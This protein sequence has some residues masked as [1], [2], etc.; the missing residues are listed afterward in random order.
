M[1]KSLKSRS[2]KG[3]V[4][5]LG[6]TILQQGTTFIVTIFLARLLS[7]A[8][9]GLVGMAMVFITI[10]QVFID[11]GFASALI[12]RQDNTNLTYSS[13]FYLNLFFGVILSSTLYFCAP[14]IGA[15][16]KN[17][18]I[19]NLVRWLSLIFVFSSLDIVQITILK[20][21][22]NFK[23][24]TI[25]MFVASIIGGVCAIIAAFL[26]LGVYSLVIQNLVTAALGTIMLW[27][28]TEWRPNL[29]FSFGEIKKLTGFSSY[30]FSDRILS[31]IVSKMDVMTIAKLFSPQVLGYY[32]RAYGLMNQ[33]TTYSSSSLNA[34]FFPV[35]SSLHKDETAYNKVY[36][37]VISVI[38]FFSYGLTGILCILG[39]DIIILLFG[40]K[41]EPSVV[42]FQVIIFM[43]CTMPLNGM[44]ANAFLSKGKSKQN[45]IIGIF[46]KLIRLIPIVLMYF[47]GMF[48]FT[49]SLVVF[50]YLSVF[51]NVLFLEKVTGLSYKTHFLHL[52]EGM[53]PLALVVAPFFYFN[54]HSTFSRLCW[55]G[56]FLIVYWLY[57][58]IMRS[59]GLQFVKRN[60]PFSKKR[61]VTL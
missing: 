60:N 40:S 31:S 16:Y 54:P 43:A 45:F 12:H 55:A 51:L 61:I 56:V 23:I 50:T 18:E 32:S 34:V 11:F 25:R 47:F 49:I 42:I 38:T 48:V 3:F 24:L 44:M 14:L 5:N 27:K 30:V 9:F 28:S 53:L 35:L 6:G 22:L 13:V 52:V 46:R 1:A 37:K 7:P 57:C 8:E 20:K 2:A 39:R 59:E 41:W 26:R 36:F 10:N 21:H 33:V 15:F 19:I 17:R 4:W 58:S 29:Q